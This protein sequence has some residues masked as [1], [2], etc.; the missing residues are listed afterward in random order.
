MTSSWHAPRKLTI[1]PSS[2]SGSKVA[3]VTSQ[4]NLMTLFSL[5]WHLHSIST[6]PHHDLFGLRYVKRGI[7]AAIFVRAISDLNQWCWVLEETWLIDCW[8]CCLF[9]L[10]ALSVPSAQL[11]CPLRSI[12]NS[13]NRCSTVHHWL[14]SGCFSENHLIW[15]GKELDPLFSSPLL[16]SPLTDSTLTLEQSDCTCHFLRCRNYLALYPAP[17]TGA[18]LPLRLLFLQ[19][20]NKKVPPA[21]QLMRAKQ[22]GSHSA[23]KREKRFSTSSFPLS[24]NR[25]LQKLLALAGMPPSINSIRSNQSS[26]AT[27]LHFPP[28]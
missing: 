3:H 6:S 18:L 13:V 2:W 21:T 25:E 9:S 11:F 15:F 10:T 16:P 8:T 28:L 26:N 20:S 22:P 4:L 14:W 12:P 1:H 19:G 24:A 5:K 27:H 23:V 17:V 7:V